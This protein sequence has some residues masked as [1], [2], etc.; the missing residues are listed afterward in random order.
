MRSFFLVIVIAAAWPN[1][2][3]QS[4]LASCPKVSSVVWTIFFDSFLQ[5]DCTP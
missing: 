5:D 2:H 3:A 4:S 1:A